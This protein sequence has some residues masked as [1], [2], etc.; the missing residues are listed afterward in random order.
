MKDTSIKYSAYFSGPRWVDLEGILG[1]IMEEFNI[2]LFVDKV[3]RKWL[4]KKV[5]FTIYPKDQNMLQRIVRTLMT[6]DTRGNYGNTI[7]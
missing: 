5:H 6:Y 3:E 2:P 4:Y 7:Y 1:A